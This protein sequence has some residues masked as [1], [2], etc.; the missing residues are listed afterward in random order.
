[1]SWST[2]RLPGGD[3]EDELDL[4]EDALD[5]GDA[6]RALAFAEGV[7]DRAPNH[8]GALFLAA[9]AYRD[10][11]A[12]GDA[13]ELYLRTAQLVPD[14]SLTW[15]GLATV[16]FD[17]LRMDEAAGALT[18]AI[19]RDPANGEAYY[20][21]ALLREWRGDHDG[22]A[23]DFRRAYR[24]DADAWPLPAALDD[25]TLEAVVESCIRSLHPTVR[26]Y[27]ANV[28]IL[29]EELPTEEV[30]RTYDPPASPAGIL[31]F[32]SGP[33]LRERSLG[34]AWSHLPARIVLFRRNLARIASDR[35][36]LL[37]ELRIT[38]FHEVG[39]LLGL[40]EEDLEERGLD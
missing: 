12:L 29:V 30:C 39:H 31:G 6:Q 28:P 16:Y 37:D 25:A 27:L 15:S 19:R 34:D 10:L 36:T 17:M 21:R 14:H 2:T 24:L 33:T 1:M 13:E 5:Q 8:P 11:R 3:A 38:L 20:W 23:R 32:F 18:K 4:A 40:D 9:E 7:L 26:A 22:A 35:E